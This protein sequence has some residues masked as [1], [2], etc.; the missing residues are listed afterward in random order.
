MR[1]SLDFARSIAENP[2]KSE[3]EQSDNFQ[4]YLVQKY[5]SGISPVHC[6]LINMVLN[7][8]L[9]SWTNKQQIFDFLKCV[10]PKGER[11]MK[12]FG[13]K[14]EKKWEN[15]DLEY[16]SDA[17]EMT[18]K[19]LVTILDNFPDIAESLESPLEKTYKKVK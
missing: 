8:K 19:D 4:P 10:I 6:N 7:D 2:E 12:Y 11:Y 9:S 18:R 1:T 16:F 17:M 5:I 3:I 15:I 13:K 14:Q